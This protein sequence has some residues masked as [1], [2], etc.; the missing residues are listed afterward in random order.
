MSSTWDPETSS[1]YGMARRSCLIPLCH[2]DAAMVPSLPSTSM[3]PMAVILL[4]VKSATHFWLTR[5]NSDSYLESF[6]ITN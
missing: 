5:I 6:L 3:Q 4:V 1:F 2:E